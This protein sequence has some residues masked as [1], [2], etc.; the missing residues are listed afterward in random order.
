MDS[1]CA[2]GVGEPFA[3]R[4]RVRYAECD[5]QGVVFNAHYPAYFDASITE[6]WRAAFGGDDVMLDCGVDVVVAEASLRFRSPA[7]FDDRLELRIAITRLGTTSIVSR[8]V[9]C[10]AGELLVEGDM[11]H[12]LVDRQLLI[13]T[14]I[15]LGTRSAGAVAGG[16]GRVAWL[17]QVRNG[18]RNRSVGVPLEEGG[19]PLLH[20]PRRVH[21]RP[22][23][24][25]AVGRSRDACLQ[26]D[27]LPIGFSRGLR[28]AT[29][30]RLS[31]P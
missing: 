25:K 2:L 7:R 3:H 5:M 23:A 4:L 12:V 18:K 11:R 9:V 27:F 19:I 8:H 26:S 13:K 15:R 1:C 6:L 21:R 31:T 28:R 20:G 14:P 24:C 29:T 17:A 16:A 22:G 30:L 10:R